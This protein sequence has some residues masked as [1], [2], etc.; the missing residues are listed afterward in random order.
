MSSR[1]KVQTSGQALVEAIE[2]ARRRL[3]DALAEVLVVVGSRANGEFARRQMGDHQSFIHVDFATPEQLVAELGTLA[4]VGAGKRPEPGGWLGAWLQANLPVMV[5]DG[6]LGRHGATLL[7]SGW[8]APIE[9]V[10]EELQAGRVTPAQLRSL[11]EDEVDG[12]RFGLLA[13]LLERV[14]AARR[15]QGFFSKTE[16]EDKALE[17]AMS[18][19]PLPCQSAR[20]VVVFGDGLLS[21]GTFRVL[22]EWVQRRDVTRL[23][24]PPLERLPSAPWGLRAA[25]SGVETA[26][27][28]VEQARHDRLGHL[29]AGL[30]AESL[31]ACM[32]DDASVE[33]VSTPDEIREMDE[34]AREVQRAILSG[35]PL[36]RIAIALPDADT[37]EALEAALRKAGIL[38]SWLTGPT[39]ER[40]AC[41]RALRLVLDIADGDHR[42]AGWY[43]LLTHSGL[44]GLERAGRGAWRSLLHSAPRER[45]IEAIL[46]HI[47]VQ[48]QLAEE[49][50]DERRA[51]AAGT[52]TNAIGRLLEA[53]ER[54]PRQASIQDHAQA[55][56]DF[57]GHWWRRQGHDGRSEGGTPD[58]ERLTEAL[59]KWGQGGREVELGRRDASLLFTEALGRTQHLRG[60][61]HRPTIRV[62]PPMALLGGS[63]ELVCAVGLTEERFPRRAGENPLLTDGMMEKLC[64]LGARLVGSEQLPL[65]ERRRFSALVAACEGKLWLSHPR[66][67][68]LERTPLLPGNLLMEAL[69]ALEGR[70]VRYSE[71]SGL[72]QPRGSR[73]RPVAAHPDEALGLGEHLLARAVEDPRRLLPVLA[74]RS[75]ARDLMALHRSVDRLINDPEA[76]PDAWT[77]LVPPELL[78]SALARGEAIG[79]DQLAGLLNDPTGHFWRDLLRVGGG[80]RPGQPRYDVTPGGLRREARRV[81]ERLMDDGGADLPARFEAAWETHVEAMGHHLGVEEGAQRQIWRREGLQARD[82]LLGPLDGAER[83]VAV[84]LDGTS[85]LP[86]GVQV[87][88]VSA[89]L[90]GDALVTLRNQSAGGVP[91]LDNHAV[92][93]AVASALALREAG[94]EVSTLVFVGADG[95]C[96]HEPLEKL[97]ADLTGKLDQAQTLARVGWWPPGASGGPLRLE[98]EKQMDK[99]VDVARIARALT[100][101]ET[102]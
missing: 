26:I 19:T 61:L 54:L 28:E 16:L 96:R 93:K 82:N 56:S 35:T 85:A 29:K 1:I 2:G 27:I 62:A 38:A 68:M 25:V 83:L 90:Q 33:V 92:I 40:T 70:R 71:L 87:E 8:R 69:S 21:P 50:G 5:A 81:M 74:A 49:A 60:G 23:A 9:S 52:L 86:G 37:A 46:D 59:R 22:R 48:R 31:M 7:R 53:M 13:T 101:E 95:S 47:E 43:A 14:A 58:L 84:R 88:G 89:H 10:V 20:A 100:G 102:P 32:A 77:G 65:V 79:I 73:A 99:T 12:E 97:A 51:R 75:S 42:V 45:G 30:Y 55:W 18:G 80:H 57:M 6:L 36:D 98:R 15:E 63:F 72:V 39:L 11:R 44:M 3:G 17:A 91:K 94:H 76:T 64:A 34:V 4:L 78:E 66:S 24:L 67:K 41:A